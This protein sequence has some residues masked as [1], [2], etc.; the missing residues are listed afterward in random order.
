MTRRLPI[1]PWALLL[2]AL[3]TAPAVGHAQPADP[4]CDASAAGPSGTALS[5]LSSA[6]DLALAG[7]VPDFAPMS[8]IVVHETADRYAKPFADALRA[9]LGDR[10]VFNRFNS[11]GRSGYTD[12]NMVWMRDYHPFYVRRADGTLKVVEYLS[13]N[14]VRMQ[15]SGASYVPGEAADSETRLYRIPGDSGEGRRLA[16]HRLP[17]ILE[18]GNLVSTGRHVFL[19]DKVLEDNA[20]NLTDPHLVNRGY[21]P[22]TR[23]E[24]IA[25]LAGA[26]EIPPENVVITPSL[27][28][29]KTDHVDLWMMPLGPG[30][31]MIP[32]IRDEAFG[33]LGFG[34][35]IELGREA[36]GF[37]DDRAREMAAMGYDVARL[38]M[39]PAV[40][41]DRSGPP[42][43]PIEALPEPPG[44]K[45]TYYSPANALLANVRGARRVLLPTTRAD[46]FPDGYRALNEQYRGEWENAFRDRDWEPTSVDA[47]ELGRHSGLFRCVSFPIPE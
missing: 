34:H 2:A 43:V 12:P 45:G 15:F 42:G 8:G 28:G 18:A 10:A 13:R 25:E 11:Q 32:E 1:L 17:L 38:P 36:Q 5:D 21:R 22:R 20:K 33:Q 4:A 6:A 19:T 41:L 3:A 29:E 37:L 35:E 9:A 46:R 30:E 31:V 47:T 26:L 7:P 23:E 16:R 39:M 40:Y 27:P 14:P 24:V 44:W